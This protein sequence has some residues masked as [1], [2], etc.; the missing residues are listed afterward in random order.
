MINKLKH[1]EKINKSHITKIL[2]K[3]IIFL[4]IN[5]LFR[6]VD[7]KK[8]EQELRELETALQLAHH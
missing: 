4:K 7:D 6:I 5:R 1:H 8:I 2:T 3:T